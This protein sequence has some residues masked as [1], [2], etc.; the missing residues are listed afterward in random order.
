MGALQMAVGFAQLRRAKRLPFPGYMAT[1]G[2]LAEMKSLYQS[3]MNEGIGS[4]QSGIMRMAGAQTMGQQMN[5][6]AQNASQSSQLFGRTAALNRTGNEARIANANFEAK[7]SAMSGV[8]RMNTAMTAIEQKD[9]AAARDYRL[10]AERA[11]GAAIKRGSENIAG[12]VSEENYYKR[13]G[14][15]KQA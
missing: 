4:E 13:S 12:Y 1:K 8:E 7:Q 14:K 10:T 3:Q 9:I 6:V 15:E 2:P 11:A 5:A